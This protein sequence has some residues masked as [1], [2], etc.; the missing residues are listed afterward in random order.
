M[1]EIKNINNLEKRIICHIDFD[2]FFAQCE[3]NRNPSIKDFPVLVCVFSG[4]TEDSGIVSTSNYVA[5]KYGIKSGISIKLARSRLKNVENVVFLP[6][7][8]E[9]YETISNKAFSL[10]LSISKV[11]N[12]EIIG[13]DECFLDLTSICRNY[14][15]ATILVKDIKNCLVNKL[16]LSCSVGIS[17]NK[18]L[19]KIAS[20]YK[21][22]NGFFIISQNETI[23]II[24]NLDISIIP[25]IGQK[26]KKKLNDLGIKTIKELSEKNITSL[27][28][29]FGNN[30]GEYLHRSSLGINEEP[31]NKKTQIKQIT[32]IKTLKQYSDNTENVRSVLLELCKSTYSEL[33]HRGLLFR[34]VGLIFIN[35]KLEVTNRS[36]NLKNYTQ[37]LNDLI[38]HVDALFLEYLSTHDLF[39]LRRIGVKV[40]ELKKSEGQRTLTNYIENI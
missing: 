22:P 30:Y 35:N 2:Y 33:R 29:T 9:Y 16:C 17:Y 38:D 23:Q 32:R 18:L 7:D 36:K 27:K 4:R 31:I 15:E 12:Y 20:E 37:N 3:E 25:G 10:I 40:S 39:K 13:L 26:N 11:I 6:I 28:K 14:Q 5:R 21:K 19:A 8:Y 34:N 24:S 1:F